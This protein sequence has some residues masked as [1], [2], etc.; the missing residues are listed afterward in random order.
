M[1]ENKLSGLRL[2]YLTYIMLPAFVSYCAFELLYY[3]AFSVSVILSVFI[4]KFLLFISIKTNE[5]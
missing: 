1:T 4:N 5:M 2:N 3:T